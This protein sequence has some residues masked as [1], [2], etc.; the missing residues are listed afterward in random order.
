MSEPKRLQT[1]EGPGITVTFD[2][3]VCIHSGACVR[4]LRA[5]FDTRR[6]R[7][8]DVEAATPDE[9][10]A[11]ID[12]CPSG[13][14]QH[15]RPGEAPR[16]PRRF[17]HGTRADLKPGDV[18]APGYG[19]NYTDRRSPWIYFSETMNAAMWGAELAKGD[20]RGRIY[21]VEPTGEFVDDPNVTNQRFPGNPTKS[22]R[23]Q[24][25]LRIVREVL[26]WKGHSPDEIAAMKSALVGKEPI[27]D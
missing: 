11:Q 13:A 18:L 20:A 12:R 5:V 6:K 3:N 24:Q 16:T 26:G 25:P 10:A 23:S 4:G 1:Y 8:I 7:W 14:L 22:F 19:S 15:H 17:F 2:P 9:I 27:D 21:E